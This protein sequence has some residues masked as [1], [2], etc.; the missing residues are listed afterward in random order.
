[1]IDAIIPTI[2]GREASLERLLDSLQRTTV[3]AYDTVIVRDSPTCG[4]GWKAGLER[5]QSPYVAF[6]CDDQEFTGKGWDGIC[7]ETVDNGGIPCPRV[8]FPDGRPESFGGDMH[9]LHHTS[10]IPKKDGTRVDYTPIPFLSREMAEEIGVLETQY[11]G[12][13]WVSYRGRQL[14]YDTILRHGFEVRH[15]HEQIGRGAGMTQ[16]ERDAMDC[17]TLWKELEKC[18]KMMA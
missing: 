11:A 1:M 6:L 3:S 2:P 13:V 18:G 5:S 12:D 4:E 8:W 14:G 10:R 16:N 17:E 9:A 7:I 15:W